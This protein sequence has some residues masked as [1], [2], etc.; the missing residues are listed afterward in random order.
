VKIDGFEIPDS[1]LKPEPPKRPGF[2]VRVKRW[3]EEM[4]G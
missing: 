3:L 2:W 4:F 1:V